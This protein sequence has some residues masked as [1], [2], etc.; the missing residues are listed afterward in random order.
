MT[1]YSISTPNEGS[2]KVEIHTDSEIKVYKVVSK[3][4][5][6]NIYFHPKSDARY[7]I[8]Q[9]YDFFENNAVR[10]FLHEKNILNLEYRVKIQSPF[11]YYN[12]SLSYRQD[13]ELNE[14]YIFLSNN[15]NKSVPLDSRF[16]LL[17]PTSED[18]SLFFEE[19]NS[20]KR[21]EI[22][23]GKM[24]EVTIDDDNLKFRKA[25]S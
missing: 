16:W 25:G 3:Q 23:R 12:Q 15:K 5:V 19:K 17:Q 24:S 7:P 13:G 18:I 2:Y 6:E 4:K 11:N 22:I 9:I 14:H 21:R 20:Q 10:K 1:I 8:V